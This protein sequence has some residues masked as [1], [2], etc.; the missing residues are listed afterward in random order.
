VTTND[1]IV[2]AVGLATCITM[3]V[4]GWMGQ[5]AFET[6]ASRKETQHSSQ[7]KTRK[8]SS[9]VSTRRMLTLS[10]L[11]IEGLAILL[12]SWR[13]SRH[14]TV[15]FLDILGICFGF[16]AMQSAVAAY[17]L[18]GVLEIAKV[19]LGITKELCEDIERDQAFLREMAIEI[20]RKAYSRKRPV[21]PSSTTPE[22]KNDS[23]T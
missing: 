8:N 5:K 18:M 11:F 19:H 14:S 17:F 6:M 7:K 3:L 21:S 2:A 15:S 12:L 9:F 20:D 23:S 22:Q 4:S 13:S 16:L 1:K 10:L